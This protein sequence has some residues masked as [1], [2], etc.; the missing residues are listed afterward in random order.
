MSRCRL[1]RGAC[2]VQTFFVSLAV[3][4]DSCSVGDNLTHV[5]LLTM[6][7]ILMLARGCTCPV[8]LIHCRVFIQVF[9][10]FWRSLVAWRILT[11]AASRILQQLPVI[12]VV[13]SL[14]GESLRSI[15]DSGSLSSVS[16]PDR[17]IS[18]LSAGF[19]VGFVWLDNFG[20]VGD[21]CSSSR[22]FHYCRVLLSFLR[23]SNLTSNDVQ[24]TPC[25]FSLDFVIPVVSW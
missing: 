6:L 17:N 1:P 22:G 12:N 23:T 14:F 19:P 16:S 11:D 21:S 15:Q 10:V 25:Q 18:F 4:C 2:S 7:W 8:I 24:K 13:F 9:K 5:S 3:R 20:F